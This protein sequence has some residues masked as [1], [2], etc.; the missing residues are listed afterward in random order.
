MKVK[1]VSIVENVVIKN[2]RGILGLKKDNVGS[3]K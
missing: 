3:S 1:R 2:V